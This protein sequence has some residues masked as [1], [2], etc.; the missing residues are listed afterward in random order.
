MI[1]G[2]TPEYAY[3]TTDP[4]PTMEGNTFIWYP[5]RFLLLVRLDDWAIRVWQTEAQQKRMTQEMGKVRI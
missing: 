2:D 5:A 4:F 3:L 1:T